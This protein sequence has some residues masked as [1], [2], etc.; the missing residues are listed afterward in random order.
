MRKIRVKRLG[1]VA[2]T[3]VLSGV[4][5]PAN[6]LDW[7]NCQ[8]STM[9]FYEW[10]GGG[11]IDSGISVSMLKETKVFSASALSSDCRALIEPLRG[12]VKREVA[13]EGF[14]TYQLIGGSIEQSSTCHVVVMVNG[15]PW[16]EG[17]SEYVQGSPNAQNFR[18]A[19][20]SSDRTNLK[21]L[22]RLGSNTFEATP[23][24]GNSLA[25][26]HT[27]T[28][29]LT[30]VQES[31]GIIAG[32]SINDGAEWTNS[33]D[34]NLT[35]SYDGLI[36]QVA[37]SNDGGFAPSK[38]QVVNYVSNSRTWTLRASSDER[39]PKVVYVRYRLYGAANDG[40]LGP[41]VSAT[42][43]DDIIL[44][45]VKPSVSTIS[46]SSSALVDDG[47][48][49]VTNRVIN[50]KITAHDN[51]SGVAKLQVSSGKSATGAVTTSF[52]KKKS[53]SVPKNWSTV[54]VRVR[55]GAGNWSTWKKAARK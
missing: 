21:E 11:N 48:R 15:K 44:D 8:A 4:V 2:F 49:T 47:F 34:V 29:T 1:V 30:V 52:S 22:L 19:L 23:S 31:A 17:D 36:A 27:L 12:I 18:P 28:G 51:K 39:L 6:A 5:S 35:F 42:L 24:C 10:P 9:T 7:N 55:D 25:S 41:W 20:S 32:V 46:F 40:S 26:G 50:L 38:T 45:T 43:T 3:L 53:I 37:V 54:Y 16:I 14:F 13:H 33:R